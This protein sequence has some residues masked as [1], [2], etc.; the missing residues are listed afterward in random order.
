MPRRREY[1]QHSAAEVH[2]V[3]VVNP[4]SDLK[5]ARGIGLCVKSS[6]QLATN[7]SACKFSQRVGRGTFRIRAR[8]IRIHAINVVKF[9]VVADMVVMRMGIHHRDWQGRKRRKYA[10]DVSNAEAGIE[11]DGAL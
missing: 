10:F 7:R 9:P 1:L 6:R 3:A 2:R 4:V 5:R 11:Q 8:E